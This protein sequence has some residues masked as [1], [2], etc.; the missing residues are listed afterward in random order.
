MS[1]WGLLGSSKIGSASIDGLFQIAG[2]QSAEQL[3]SLPALPPPQ[4][5]AELSAVAADA[6][7]MTRQ[8]SSSDQADGAATDGAVVRVRA[9]SDDRSSQPL[10]AWAAAASSSGRGQRSGGGEGDEE[11]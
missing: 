4:E 2:S 7:V 10:Q 8:R 9:S 3:P 1:W 11:D 5:A 6:P